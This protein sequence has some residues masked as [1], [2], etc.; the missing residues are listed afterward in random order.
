MQRK[1][2][3]VLNF[4]VCGVNACVCACACARVCAC[5]CACT[6]ES[7]SVH[8]CERDSRDSLASHSSQTRTTSMFATCASF[9]MKQPPPPPP[10]PPH[11]HHHHHYHHNPDNNN[12]TYMFRRRGHLAT[13]LPAVAQL[14][15]VHACGGQQPHRRAPVVRRHS[16]QRLVQW[17]LL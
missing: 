15:R 17:L 12:T 2:V 4:C 1:Q 13:A 16:L 10:P 3:C 11:H 5:V 8:R 6:C 14:V 9:L 7:D